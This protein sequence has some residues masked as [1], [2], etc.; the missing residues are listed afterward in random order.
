MGSTLPLRLTFLFQT[1]LHTVTDMACPPAQLSYETVTRLS[2]R[3]HSSARL[4]R[5][6]AATN[7]LVKGVSQRLVI[8]SQLVNLGLGLWNSVDLPNALQ[9]SSSS[10]LGKPGQTTHQIVVSHFVHWG[11]PVTSLVL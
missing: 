10:F 6:I 3:A 8:L 11:E 2:K 5:L 7:L 4:T 1:L 9:F